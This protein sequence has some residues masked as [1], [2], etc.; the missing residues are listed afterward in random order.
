MEKELTLI[1]V[2]GATLGPES[3]GR[4]TGLPVLVDAAAGGGLKFPDFSLL[5]CLFK[6]PEND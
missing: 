2:P 4:P 1:A 3:L 5:L 6:S